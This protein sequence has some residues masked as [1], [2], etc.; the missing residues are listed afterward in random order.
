MTVRCRDARGKVDS[1][2]SRPQSTL[3]RWTRRAV[4]RLRGEVN[5]DR[6]VSEGLQLGVGVRVGMPVYLDPGRPWLVSIGDDTEISPFVVV[7]A[8]DAS[9]SIQIGYTRLAQVIIGRR[10]FV[11]PGALILPGSRIGDDSVIAAGAVVRGEIPPGCVAAGNPAVVVSDAASYV[12]RHR[13]EAARGRQWSEAEWSTPAKIT[14]QRQAAEREALAGRTSC[15]VR[16]RV[17]DTIVAE[18]E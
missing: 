9:M 7:L 16:T 2:L 14:R 5:L 11:G 6:L 15:Y 4:D 10:V 13:E 8:H 17:A 12:A 1:R 3:Y 18:T